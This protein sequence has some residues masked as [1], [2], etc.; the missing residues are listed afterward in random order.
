MHLATLAVRGNTGYEAAHP[1]A[2]VCIL[3]PSRSAHVS[4][5][6]TCLKLCWE[7]RITRHRRYSSK[8]SVLL[9]TCMALYLVNLSRSSTFRIGITKN[10]VLFP[11]LLSDISVQI[12]NLILIFS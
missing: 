12:W 11:L 8:N 9:R 5:S 7:T 10:P 3:L 1:S 2:A 6:F 4:L